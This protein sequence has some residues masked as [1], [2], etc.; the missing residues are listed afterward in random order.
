MQHPTVLGLA[1]MANSNH[2]GSGIGAFYERH[3]A[4]LRYGN[5]I[6]DVILVPLLALNLVGLVTINGELAH[7]VISIIALIEVI[8]TA[9]LLLAGYVGPTKTPHVECAH[10][11]GKMIPIV[12]KW[13][14]EGCGYELAPPSTTGSTTVS[15]MGDE[16]GPAGT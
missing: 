13:T 14:C 1:S 8:S 3:A 16:S 12:S 5:A 4:N 9:M 15:K 7:W 2:L 6:A 10:C 11:S